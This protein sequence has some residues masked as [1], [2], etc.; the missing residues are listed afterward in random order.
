MGLLAGCL[1]LRS[2]AGNLVKGPAGCERSSAHNLIPSYIR[3]TSAHVF[4]RV[5]RD[6]Y[7]HTHMCTHVLRGRA[8]N[9]QM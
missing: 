2:P 3:E 5:C 7:M 6:S 9:V 1:V 8:P 4:V